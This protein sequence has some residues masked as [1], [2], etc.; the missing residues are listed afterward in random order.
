[1]KIGQLSQQTDCG[2]ETIRYYE[3]I[4]LFPTPGRSDGGYRIYSSEHLQ[5][6]NFIRRGR[7]LGFSIDE[8]RDMLGMIDDGN[9]AC[10]DINDIAMRHVRD[11]RRKIRDLKRL[12]KTLTGIAEHCHCDDLPQ[13]AIIDSLYEVKQ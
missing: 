1:M 4:G 13:C 8:I 7:A 2:V 9:I 12:E 5:R 10:G 11:I 6:L 3:K